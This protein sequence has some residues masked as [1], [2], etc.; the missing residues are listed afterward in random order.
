VAPRLL[1]L[2]LSHCGQL[3]SL[4][5]RCKRLRELKAVNCTHL[6]LVAGELL[7]P[8]LETLNL[9]GCRQLDAEGGE[10]PHRC[11][12][13]SCSTL[14]NGS[15]PNC[16]HWRVAGLEAVAPSL[17][18]LVSLDLTGCINLSRVLLP[19]AAA[20]RSIR[21]GQSAA[22]RSR[23]CW[24]ARGAGKAACAVSESWCVSCATHTRHASLLCFA[25]LGSTTAVVS[26]IRLCPASCLVPGCSV[27]GC[28]VL[29]QVL[30]ASPALTHVKAAGCARLLVS[31]CSC[32]PTACAHPCSCSLPHSLALPLRGLPLLHQ[33]MSLSRRP[34]WAVCHPPLAARPGG[35]AGNSQPGC[36]GL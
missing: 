7:C 21:C 32:L 4:S 10:A 9:F 28:S 25:S 3:R 5:L 15:C 23:W 2:N 27:S 34:A 35:A 1:T 17:T 18:K 22:A 26:L 30:L 12:C 8:A 29:R 31:H 13:C 16:V 36:P 14:L 19:E 6:N 24:H 20:L 33:P 11:L